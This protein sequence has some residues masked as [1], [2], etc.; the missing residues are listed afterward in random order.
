MVAAIPYRTFPSFDVGP[1]TVRT[2][3]VFVALGILVGVWLFLRYARDRGLDPDLLSRLAWQVIVL[4]IVGSR[5]LFVITNWGSFEDDPLSVFALWEGG[6]QFAGSFL[7][8]IIVIWWFARRHPEMPGFALSDGVV[9]GLAPGLVIGRLGCVAVG[10]HLG[11]QTSFLLGW[12]Y[13]GGETREPVAGGVDSVI[14]NTAIYEMVLLLPLVGLLWWMQRRRVPAG[15]LTATFLLWYG[16]QRFLTDFLRAY[17][18]TVA[19]LTGAQYLSLGMVA[20]GAL[21]AWR[22]RRGGEQVP[23]AMDAEPGRATET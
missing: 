6:L 10:E 8:S 5:V 19:G 3:G 2:F 16:T 9:Y 11:T 7:I 12:K 1:I 14:H 15:W 20:G 18:E 13:L 21:L 22:L 17:D 4:G 23:T